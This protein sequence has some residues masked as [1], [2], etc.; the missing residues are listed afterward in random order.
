MLVREYLHQSNTTKEQLA[1][2]LGHQT[3]S[4]VTKKMDSEMPKRWVRLLDESD[5]LSLTAVG[6]N[7]PDEDSE[8]E[9]NIN[10]GDNTW[11]NLGRE[12]D[13]D[14]VR[15]DGANHVVGP[16]TI[17]LSTVEDYIGKIYSGAAYIARDKFND[18]LA[19]DVII[20]YSPEFAEAWIEYIKSDPRI[21]AYLEKMLVGTPLGNLIGVHV[22]AIGS[23]TIARIVARDIS[24]SFAESVTGEHGT[25]DGS[26]ANSLG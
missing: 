20:Q 7:E 14:P 11:D 8:R 9:P 13:N 17:K 10:D 25:A 21:M 2:F 1:E 23:Y 6:E 12:S 18:E 5:G 22:I 24:R 19:S 3:T 15:P 16:K 4:S 26:T